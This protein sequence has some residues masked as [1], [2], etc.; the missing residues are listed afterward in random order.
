MFLTESD[1]AILTGRKIKRLQIEALTNMR[2]P[3]FINACGRPVVARSAIDGHE[4]SKQ[5]PTSREPW[6]PAVLQNVA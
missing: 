5:E 4:P 3:F 6:V 2:I 1:I